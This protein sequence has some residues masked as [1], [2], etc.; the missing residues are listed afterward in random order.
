MYQRDGKAAYKADLSNTQKLMQHLGNPERGFKSV[1]VAGTNGKGS[2][3]SMLASVLQ[4][5]GY[6]VGLYTSPH[7][8]DFR[9]RIKI[10]GELIAKREVIHFVEKNRAFFEANALS[11]FEMTVGLAFQY[12]R[13]QKVDI[14]I[15]EVGM[16]G[17]LDSTNVLLP[18]LCVITNIGRDHTQ[19]LGG[20]LAGIAAEKAG[21]IKKETPVV[22]GEAKPETE[23][24]F[25]KF[26]EKNNAEII[27][28]ETKAFKSYVS[29]L[30]GNYQQKN[31]KTAVAVLQQLKKMGWAISG[32]HIE[33]GLLNVVK[34]TGLKGRWQILKHSPKVICDTAHNTDGLQLTMQQLATEKYDRLHMVLGF[35][36]G[37]NL[38]E[39]L[40]L[41]PKKAAYYFC[42]P[43]VPR[44]LSAQTVAGAANTFGLK[45]K[46][47]P[48]VGIAHKATLL[49]AGTHDVIYIGGSTF[50]VAE[51]V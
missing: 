16:G 19:F 7:L 17:R 10:N 47:Y 46:V 12:F 49:A 23:P 30:K 21:V 50:T 34:N 1:H 24:V 42:R 32:A 36:K 25:T 5:A 37:K 33:K 4:G 6:K 13:S 43:N 35:V 8:V 22:I 39:I 41:F 11:F 2:T 48:S 31:I 27:F 28:A 44:G 51:V 38:S 9:E 14:A 45:G 26:A 20:T 18:E 15:V 40:P 29:D 3:S